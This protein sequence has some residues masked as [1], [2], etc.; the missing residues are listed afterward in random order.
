MLSLPVSRPLPQKIKHIPLYVMVADNAFPLQVNFLVPYNGYHNGGSFQR[1]VHYID[2]LD[3]VELLKMFSE[4]CL[5]F[6][7]FLRKP[8]LLNPSKS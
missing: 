1:I 3:I 4:L 6:F 8:I 2:Y 5:Q 7:V